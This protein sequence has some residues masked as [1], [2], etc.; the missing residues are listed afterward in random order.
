MQK[1]SISASLN[2][3]K[4]TCQCIETHNKETD[5]IILTLDCYNHVSWVS[6]LVHYY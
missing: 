3:Y 4:S 6:T 1:M 2:I 5:N